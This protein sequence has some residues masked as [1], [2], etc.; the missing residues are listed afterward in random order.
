MKRILSL[1]LLVSG[2]Q[3]AFGQYDPKALEILEDMS[4]KYNEIPSFQ[5]QFTYTLHN[6]QENINEE[7]N[8][9]VTVKGEKFRLK[10]GG[11]EIYNNG[12][13]VWTYLPEVNEVNID[14]YYP[15]SGDLSP[16]KI[17]SAYR[18][19]YKYMFLEE[20]KEGNSTYEVVDLI[21]EDANNQFFKIRLKIDKN[22]NA[23]K[24]WEMFDKMGN[25]Y[26]YMV[27]DFNAQADI[28]DN[29]F[30][31]DPSRHRGVEIID[32]R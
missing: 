24:S 17:Y 13:T 29:Y 9:E 8:G 28:K 32:L 18:D 16:S 19:G 7:F 25:R 4:S 15:E 26:K 5:A 27:T 12:N 22:E 11:Q 3:F 23:L 1:L 2:F 10:M 31:F 30:E 14:N 21:P 6:P 20:A